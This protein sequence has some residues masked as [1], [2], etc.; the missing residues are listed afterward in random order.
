MFKLYLSAVT[1]LLA[2]L[3]NLIIN[4]PI[5]FEFVYAAITEGAKADA[6]VTRG[7]VVAWVVLKCNCFYEGC[8][9]Q[10]AHCTFSVF[11]CVCASVY[12]D[13]CAHT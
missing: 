6:V 5:V 10:T 1:W 3:S 9:A 7:V 12:G 8:S 4:I 13:Q 2:I 11:V